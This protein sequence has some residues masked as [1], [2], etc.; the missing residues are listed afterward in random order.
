MFRQPIFFSVELRSFR[1][2]CASYLVPEIDASAAFTFASFSL[3]PSISYVVSAISRFRPRMKIWAAQSA[4]HYK[5][6]IPN[7]GW[8][9]NDSCNPLFGAQ[10]VDGV[11]KLGKACDNR[12]FVERLPFWFAVRRAISLLARIFFDAASLPED[13]QRNILEQLRYRHRAYR[14]IGRVRQDC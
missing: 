12:I 13:V 11:G 4:T 1:L 14:R 9:E 3:W 7:L 2:C 5:A 10:T 6:R 8:R